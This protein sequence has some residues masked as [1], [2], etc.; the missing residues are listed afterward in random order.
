MGDFN[1][2]VSMSGAERGS[3]KDTSMMDNV[4]SKACSTDLFVPQYFET[5]LK[6]VGA[7]DTGS[8]VEQLENAVVYPPD[9]GILKSWAIGPVAFVAGLI[10]LL[11]GIFVFR[12]AVGPRRVDKFSTSNKT[13]VVASGE[14]RRFG[15]AGGIMDDGSVDSAFYTDSDSDLEETEKERRM[16]LKRKDK[17]NEQRR[18]NSNNKALEKRASSRRLS[19][20]KSRRNNNVREERKLLAV[21]QR[22]DDTRESIPLS[23]GDD[24]DAKMKQGYRDN[25]KKSSTKR[26]SSSIKNKHLTS[27]RHLKRG[28]SKRKGGDNAKTYEQSRIV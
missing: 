23:S 18:F 1:A 19:T 4:Y 8:L 15:E 6:E 9:Y 14:M 25:D 11:I 10:V 24:E 12:R 2:V 26:L 27:D 3:K 22:S 7:R 28:R 21:S 13:K 17:A 16:R 5:S 20:K